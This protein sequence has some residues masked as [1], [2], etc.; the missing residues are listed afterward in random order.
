MDNVATYDSA[1]STNRVLMDNAITDRFQD[2]RRDTLSQAPP[3]LATLVRYEK[4]AFALAAIMMLAP[5]AMAAW[6]AHHGA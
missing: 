4:I 2:T 5:L 6:G 1:I 3:T